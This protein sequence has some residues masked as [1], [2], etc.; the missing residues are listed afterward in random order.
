M[1]Q[2]GGRLSR[3]AYIEQ[4]QER[5]FRKGDRLALARAEQRLFEVAGSGNAVVTHRATGRKYSLTLADTF[6]LL[7]SFLS[8]VQSIPSRTPAASL[9]TRLAAPGTKTPRS[10]FEA[11]AARAITQAAVHLQQHN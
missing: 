2:T 7:P 8:Q 6:P 10:G 1:Q 11:T 5:R 9:P 4:Q 3:A